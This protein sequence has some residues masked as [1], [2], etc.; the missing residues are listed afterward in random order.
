MVFLRRNM[1]TMDHISIFPPD[2]NVENNDFVDEYE[3]EELF[4][5]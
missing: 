5:E 4:D 1:K 3:L 2:L